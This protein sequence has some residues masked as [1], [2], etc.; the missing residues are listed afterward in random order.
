MRYPPRYSIN[1]VSR[2]VIVKKLE[3]ASYLRRL[4]ITY[5]VCIRNDLLNRLKEFVVFV[6]K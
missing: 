3:L 1:D 4:C 5:M 6:N 2:H